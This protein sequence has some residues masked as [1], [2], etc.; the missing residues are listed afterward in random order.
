MARSWGEVSGARRRRGWRRAVAAHERRP[1][2]RHPDH[3]RRLPEPRLEWQVP[4]R[5]RAGHGCSLAPGQAGTTHVGLRFSEG[6]GPALLGMPADELRN[7]T[8]N[9]D[10]IWPAL[11]ARVLT[12]RVEADPSGALESWIVERGIRCPSDSFGMRVLTLVNA[13]ASV[14]AM[15]ARLGINTRQLHRRCLAT[16]GCGPRHLTRVMRFGRALEAIR[17]WNALGSGSRRLATPTKH[18]SR[19][20][21]V[22]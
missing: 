16:F 18:T 14:A 11:S 22:S 7:R 19:G 13:G 1:T 5:R 8:P 2:G 15:A 3:A 17:R 20:K 21:C 6:V 4:H 12:E 9:L 10:D